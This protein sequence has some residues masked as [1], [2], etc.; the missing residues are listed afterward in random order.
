MCLQGAG[1]EFIL[2]LKKQKKLSEAQGFKR[3]AVE[4][5]LQNLRKKRASIQEVSDNLARDADKLAE[6]AEGKQGSKMAELIAKS[7]AFR[8]SHRDKQAELKNINVD[9][10][11]K[12]VE[13]RNL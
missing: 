13:L 12:G 6:Q 8:R 2:K 4:E 7:N 5:Q 3:K 1:I 11:A 10:V 9:I